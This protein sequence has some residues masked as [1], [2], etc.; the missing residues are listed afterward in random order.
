MKPN[1]VEITVI[2]RHETLKAL[3]VDHGGKEPCWVPKSQVEIEANK[4]GK[5]YTL[6][7]PQTLAED[8]R[9]V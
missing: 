5:T 1:L 3:L 4:D 9:M 2:I 7:L 8:K 6:T